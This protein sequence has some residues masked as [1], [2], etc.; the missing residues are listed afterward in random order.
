MEKEKTIPLKKL[1]ESKEFKE[2]EA[3]LPIALGIDFGGKPVV[4]DLAKMPH[5]L[6]AGATGSGKSAGVNAMILSLLN[7]CRPD[8]CKFIMIDPK[9][10][11][12]SIYSDI[13]HLMIPVVTDPAK[14]VDALEWSV[15]EMEERNKKIT[16]LGA[17][18]IESYNAK[19]AGGKIKPMPYIVIAVGEMSD[20][21][22]VAAKKVEAAIARL[23]AMARAAGMHL[24]LSTQRPSDD[25]LT[26]T[27]RCNFLNRIAY[28]VASK[29]DS[30]TVIDEQGAESLG[31]GEMIYMSIGGSLTRIHGAYV[32]ENEIK[33]I[34]ASIS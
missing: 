14:A 3:K 29:T 17:K 9:M 34:V 13:P 24:I 5:M 23:A 1:L 26:G 4:A 16:A 10:S 8:E 32:G 27:I 6:I 7:K 25:V 11:E 28:R 20:M 15:G 33:R 18:N 19:L 30:R 31:K 21:M 22:L 2:S 12:F